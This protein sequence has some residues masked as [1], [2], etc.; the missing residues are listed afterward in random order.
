MASQ[1][2]Q[3]KKLQITLGSKSVA[4][5]KT[6]D[7]KDEKPIESD[8][9]EKS[10]DDGLTSWL[11]GDGGDDELGAWMGADNAPKPKTGAKPAKNAAL[12]PKED[13]QDALRK[14]LSGE[15]DTLEDWLGGA[16]P[17]KLK[18]AGPDISAVG[19]Q[20]TEKDKMLDQRE[21]SIKAKEEE[22][23]GLK[24]ELDE[25]R[26][27]ME[28]A[29]KSIDVGDFDAIKILEET[30]HLNK[31]LNIEQRKRKQLEEEI[32]QVKKGS[33][34]V[35]KYVKAQQIQDKG[36]AAKSLKK[37]LDEEKAKREGLEVELKKSEELMKVLKA[38][39]DSGLDKLPD[40][41]K[42]AKKLSIENAELKKK[43]EAAETDLIRAKEDFNK[44]LRNGASSGEADMEFQQRMAAELSSKEQ[45]WITKEGALKQKIIEMEEKLHGFEIDD[46]LRKEK[47]DLSGKSDS[48]ISSEMDMKIRELQ[49]KEKSL[50]VREDEI[51]R[52]KEKLKSMEGELKQVK[53]PLAYKEQEMLRREEDLVYREQMLIEERRKVEEAMRESGSM[54]SHEMKKKLEELQ[55]SINRKEEEIRSKEQ[56]LK[57]KSEELKVREKGLIEEEIDAREEDR[58]IELKI[59]KVKTGDRRLDDLLLGGIPF[60][61]NILIYGP[62]FTGKEVTINSFIGEGLAKGVPAILVITDKL[63]SEVREEMMFIV[64]GFEEYE[65]LGLV[66]FV[67]AYSRSI[68]IEDEEAN[69][70]YVAEPTDHQGIMKAVDGVAKELLKTHKYYRLAF[71]SISTLIAYLDSGT[72]FKFLQPFCG[73]RKRE[74]AVCMYII[75]KGMHE[76]QDI[77]MIASI[78]DGM[79]DYKV[80]QL[81]TFLSIKGICD[82][83]SRAWIDYSHSKQGLSIGSFSLDHIR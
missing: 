64:S 83:Q 43:I 21:Q 46:R 33:L 60:G 48:E 78:T 32:Q 9:A 10:D 66:K 58:K 71:R 3:G 14:W 59:E 80:E 39:I 12:P 35:V 73:K 40:D 20:L 67:D 62:A 8:K 1:Q 7:S 75:E 56:Y 31:E 6:P 54:E 2:K 11:S 19:K 16:K 37:K 77:Q 13:G 76:E 36:G 53:E 52:L 55:M 50:L 49:V 29:M 69:V 81:K 34:A 23:E 42:D 65:R 51:Q 68:G 25:T 5:A 22:L 26:K 18:T 45:E 74:R 4:H 72:V 30:A 27:A 41:M 28:A 47:N 57:A 63:P 38:E 44:K 24:I 15:D 70:I 82:V 17:T 61:T 79:V